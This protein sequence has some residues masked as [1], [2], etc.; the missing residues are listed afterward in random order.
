MSEVSSVALTSIVFTS[1]SCING[2][3]SNDRDEFTPT[4]ASDRGGTENDVLD[5]N[6][7]S[8][9]T[10]PLP[11]TISSIET[12]RSAVLFT[13]M[14][15]SEVPPCASEW[16]ST[17][18]SSMTDCPGDEKLTRTGVAQPLPSLSPP[19]HS[20]HASV[21]APPSHI[22]VQSVVP[23]QQVRSP[24]EA[25]CI[26]AD[27][28][29]LPAQSSSLTR[30]HW[31][32]ASRYWLLRHDEEQVEEGSA[33]SNSRVSSE[34]GSNGSVVQGKDRHVTLSTPI[35]PI[36][37][38]APRAPNAHPL[39]HVLR[40]PAHV[41][42]GA[43][44]AYVGAEDDGDGDGTTVAPTRE[45]RKVGEVEGVRVGP[46][47]GPRVGLGLGLTVGIKVGLRL[48]VGTAVGA[49]LGNVLGLSVML[50]L[51]VLAVGPRV[52]V[53]VGV[54]VGGPV[55]VTFMTPMSSGCTDVRFPPL[56]AQP[57]RTDSTLDA[58]IRSAPTS[59][60][61]CTREP[62]GD[63]LRDPLTEPLSVQGARAVSVSR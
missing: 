37:P 15:S 17:R 61:Y 42:E 1:N 43:V 33:Y 40:V 28:L 22:P 30:Q 46:R 3:N 44:N 4:L 32:V 31:L 49:S 38:M 36:S 29:H 11:V 48:R 18:A 50:G 58:L 24:Q 14:V 9:A 16:F 34:R 54:K 63:P 5:R 53:N 27:P 59:H 47:V 56:A 20:A 13:V 8:G 19:P 57:T 12:A 2:R 6:V 35:A 39:S 26:E 52:G 21:I 25:L 45:G 60:K 10:D 23:L 7:R 62:L 51:G 41:A 55:T